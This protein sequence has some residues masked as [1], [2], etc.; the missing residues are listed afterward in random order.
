MREQ[1][2]KYVSHARFQ[3]VMFDPDTL[4]VTYDPARGETPWRPQKGRCQPSLD[5]ATA[6]IATNAYRFAQ[7][8]SIFV[9]YLQYEC[10]GC[11]A[12]IDVCDQGDDKVKLPRLIRY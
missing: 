9:T 10:I 12:C 2:C 7:Q 1:V 8:V 6:L 3:S 4:I 11:A 5:S